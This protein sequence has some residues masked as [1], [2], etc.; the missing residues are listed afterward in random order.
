MLGDCM[1]AALSQVTKSYGKVQAL[2][3]LSLDFPAGQVV[4]LLG[5][6]GSGKT[7][8]MKLISGL[9]QPDDGGVQ[10]MAQPP[11][12]SRRHVTFLGDKQGFPH[13]MTPKDMAKV[14]AALY[15]DF[16]SQVFF[17]LVSSLD[18]PGQAVAEMSRGQQQKLRLA[19]TM[20]RETD[21]YLLDEPLAGIDIVARSAILESLMST[22]NPK[23][24][25]VI[26]T[27]EI[28]DVEPH[29]T[30]A[31]FLVGGRIT[32]DFEVQ[33]LRNEG[34]SLADLFVSKMRESETRRGKS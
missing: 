1:I 26:S 32:D 6:N 15:A 9:L 8:I 4:G 24:T 30:R 7:T 25:L 27:H 17:D 5:L 3:S 31:L 2:S 20:A 21:L 33:P 13:W 14:M 11:R 34:K 10:L 19:T 22:W 29:L 23:S 16:R 12:I 18:V 28:H